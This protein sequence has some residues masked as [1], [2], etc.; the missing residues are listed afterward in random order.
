MIRTQLFQQYIGDIVVG[1]GIQALND[2]AYRVALYIM[3]GGKCTLWERLSF[4]KHLH[5]VL[6]EKVSYVFPSDLKRIGDGA[7]DGYRFM[8]D[9]NLA[10]Y[11][12]LE[13]ES[14][15]GVRA[16]GGN[17]RAFV[18]RDGG[19]LIVNLHRFERE[20][21][22]GDGC[23]SPNR[24]CRN[25]QH[26]NCVEVDSESGNWSIVG[27]CAGMVTP[28]YFRCEETGIDDHLSGDSIDT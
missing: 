16:Y 18:R 27:V 24:G 23:L 28:C 21:K 9:G 1:K 25:D 19:N 22:E 7:I 2:V 20:R 5:I 8:G 13:S 26:T 15:V 11:L 17:S 10:C 3:Q 4:A 12:D 6:T 14:F